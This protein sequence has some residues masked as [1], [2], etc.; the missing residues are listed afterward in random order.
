MNVSPEERLQEVWSR[1]PASEKE[2][3]LQFAEF[4]A[5][6]RVAL[7]ISEECFTEEEH[8]RVLAALDAVAAL[9]QE[10]GLV[11]SNRT[12]DVDLYGKS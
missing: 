7:P 6:R 11:V 8:T 4:L 10:T 12:H 3:V 2:V 5:Q 1:L 9:T